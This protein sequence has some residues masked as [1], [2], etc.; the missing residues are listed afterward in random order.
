[1]WSA[2][3][4]SLVGIVDDRYI[5]Y[6]AGEQ[7]NTYR[8]RVITVKMEEYTKR[9]GIDGSGDAI[10]EAI[11]SAF[12]L[13]TKRAFWLEDEDNIVRALGREMPM[14]NYILHIDEGSAQTATLISYKVIV[15]W[16]SLDHRVKLENDNPC[17]RPDD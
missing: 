1:M 13:R 7:R 12:G 11:K 5:P 3:C 10:K 9:I 2:F 6:S 4:L 17:C 8:G 15:G 16:S 14:G